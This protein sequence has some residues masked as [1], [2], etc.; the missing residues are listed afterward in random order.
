MKDDPDQQ[1]PEQD[2]VAAAAAD[3]L[4]ELLGTLADAGGAV[5][6]E[7]LSAIFKEVCRKTSS[8][9][10]LIARWYHGAQADH[11]AALRFAVLG[12]LE[13]VVP[14]DRWSWQDLEALIRLAETLFFETPETLDASFAVMRILD[15]LGSRLHEDDFVGLHQAC[16]SC[17]IEWRAI[18]PR[19]FWE[20]QWQSGHRYIGPLVFDGLA[21]S[22]PS[23][24][25]EWLATQYEP[26]E[27]GEQLAAAIGPLLLRRDHFVIRGD[28]EVASQQLSDDH[29]A[30]MD[31]VLSDYGL[32]TSR[33]SSFRARILDVLDSGKAERRRRF[34]SDVIE[35]VIA[36][37]VE[38][39]ERVNDWV[40]G[41]AVYDD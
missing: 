34:E 10:V 9:H 14:S 37:D 24:A 22:D 38:V 41:Q 16:L 36:E 35:R 39:T 3:S 40:R 8:P 28:L 26:E 15:Q 33:L 30:A 11:R 31:G 2:Q 1:H 19:G 20:Y 4:A 23:V 27:F 29:R 6:F 25:V 5:L 13:L 18:T 32:P 12:N 7:E 17:L 21:S